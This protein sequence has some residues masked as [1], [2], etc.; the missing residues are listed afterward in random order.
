MSLEEQGKLGLRDLEVATDDY[1]Q[2]T[3]DEFALISRDSR[4]AFGHHVEHKGIVSAYPKSAADEHADGEG[5]RDVAPEG[6]VNPPWVRNI[7][8][9]LRREEDPRE[10]P[11]SGNRRLLEQQVSR[12]TVSGKG[13]GAG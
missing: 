2:M 4:E 12:S 7:L 10:A 9:E 11:E 5:D 6:A 8:T 3:P 1:Y 13:G